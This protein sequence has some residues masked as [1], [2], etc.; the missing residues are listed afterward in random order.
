MSLE[1]DLLD[2]SKRVFTKEQDCL[3]EQ[4]RVR[5]THL[6]ESV[7][8]ILS[9]EDILDLFK[10]EVDVWNGKKEQLEQQWKERDANIKKFC[11]ENGG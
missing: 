7:G 3:E 6:A 10:D 5:A 9:M 8:H 4:M 1:D 11:Q 2:A